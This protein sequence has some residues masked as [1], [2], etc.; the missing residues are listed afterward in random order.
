MHKGFVLGLRVILAEPEQ[1]DKSGLM[2]LKTE[3]GLFSN[4]DWAQTLTNT[5][6]RWFLPRVPRQLACR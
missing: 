1:H 4:G 5:L 2:Q 3:G 6:G